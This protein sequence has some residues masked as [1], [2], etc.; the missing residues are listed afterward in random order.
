MKLR[1]WRG[2]Y[3]N[4]RMRVPGVHETKDMEMRI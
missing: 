4:V 1:I 2:E 3:D